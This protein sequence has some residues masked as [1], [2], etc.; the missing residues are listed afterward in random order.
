MASLLKQQDAPF[1]KQALSKVIPTAVRWGSQIAKNI[2][3][4]V[5]TFGRGV[6][7]GAV[8][9]AVKPAATAM[10]SVAKKMKGFT[11]K[12]RL[13]G[14]VMPATVEGKSIADRI[15]NAGYKVTD[16]YNK[17]TGKFKAV[18]DNAP[19]VGGWVLRR[20][21]STVPAA[22]VAAGVANSV[23]LEFPGSKALEY[24]GDLN[25]VYAA[26]DGGPALYYNGRRFLG[27]TNYDTS[28]TTAEQIAR[29]LGD[30]L[31]SPALGE[32]LFI[33]FMKSINKHVNDK[34]ADWGIKTYNTDP[35][36]Q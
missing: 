15:W 7:N 35:Q 23:G 33:E 9:Y 1:E 13:D 11:G 27:Q 5:K 16:W 12:Y 20:A 17:S 30:K 24:S 36:N 32:K 18:A 2:P 31:S 19:G 25:P 26:M 29:G 34:Y 14:T 3:Q 22:Q 6:L 10:K 8:H 28:V 21:P 4:G